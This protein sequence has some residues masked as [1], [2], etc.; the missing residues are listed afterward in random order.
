MR[1]RIE[2]F[3]W[4]RGFICFLAAALIFAVSFDASAGQKKKKG[5]DLGQQL[6]RF[7]PT[8]EREYEVQGRSV[9]AFQRCRLQLL[10]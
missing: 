8:S 9:G 4:M 3:A 5:K 2:E 1:K 10:S 6:G 7:V